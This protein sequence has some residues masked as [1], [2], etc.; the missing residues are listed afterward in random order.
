LLSG[1]LFH[2]FCGSI[3]Q[4][5]MRA[6]QALA[7]SPVP[8]RL[9]WGYHCI[10][11]V[12]GGDYAGAIEAYDQAYDVIKT[13][14]AWRA[15]AL[16]EL[17]RHEVARKEAQR[18]L[19]GTRSFWVGPDAPTE[20]AI[21]RWLLQAHPITVTSRWEALRSSLGGAGLPVEGI[22]QLSF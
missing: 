2:A 22:V 16:Y 12:L 20:S 3:E 15:A 7:L 8:S 1:G 5:R 6:E 11:R 10:I 13:L 21:T 17:G 14:P 4:A 18:A 9:E 19:N